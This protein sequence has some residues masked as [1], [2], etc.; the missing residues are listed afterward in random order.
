MIRVVIL[1]LFCPV[2][3]FGNRMGST[4]SSNPSEIVVKRRPCSIVLEGLD[5]TGK[6]TTCAVLAQRLN[7]HCMRTPPESMQDFRKYF[8]NQSIDARNSYYMVGN[9]LAGKDMQRRTEEGET[10]VVDRYYA[11]TIA[12]RLGQDNLVLPPISD[13]VYKW[14]KELPLPTYMFLLTLPESDRIDR[15]VKRTSIPETKEERDIK[16]QPA[17][18]ERINEAFRRMGCIE[19]PLLST[20]CVDKVVQKIV[21]KL[22][23]LEESNAIKE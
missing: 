1:L 4:T 19:I 10:V 23:M 20:D 13:D 15:L 6:S 11:S 3:L 17:T 18:G 21:E 2:S 8:D 7:A 9:F 5:G 14:P 12:Y 22:D 16:N